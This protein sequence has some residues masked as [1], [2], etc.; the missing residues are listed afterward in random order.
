MKGDQNADGEAPY[1]VQIAWNTLLVGERAGWVNNTVGANLAGLTPNAWHHMAA[2]F[3]DSTR[4]VTIYIDGTRSPRAP[5]PRRP[6]TAT[7]CR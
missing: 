2:T 1:I 5:L 3:V 4:V 6:P 7:A